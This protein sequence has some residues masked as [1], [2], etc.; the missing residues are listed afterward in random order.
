M[1]AVLRGP[2]PILAA[3]GSFCGWGGLGGLRHEGQ[4]DPTVIVAT[5]PH[6]RSAWERLAATESPAAGAAY[7]GGESLGGECHSIFCRTDVLVGDIWLAVSA[8]LSAAGAESGSEGLSEHSFHE[9]VQSIVTAVAA[10]PVPTAAP[11]L[12]A[13]PHCEEA[14]GAIQS[15]YGLRNVKA[16]TWGESF[17]IE[18]AALRLGSASQC[19]YE[20]TEARH[21]AVHITRM[22]NADAVYLADADATPG[23]ARSPLAIPGVDGETVGWSAMG[24]EAWLTGVNVLSRGEWVQVSAWGGQGTEP[25][26][27]V[28]RKLLTSP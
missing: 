10:A 7:E 20:D 13:R 3:N 2:W 17:A 18:S 24:E 5:L 4:H 23:V 22:S 27:E 6:A 21:W 11:A 19:R 15:V 16:A 25:V 26:A 9:Y 8:N 12:A 1:G 14:I 28:A